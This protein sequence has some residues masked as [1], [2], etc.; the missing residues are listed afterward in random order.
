MKLA[1]ILILAL[2]LMAMAATASL[3]NTNFI[4]SAAPTIMTLNGR[5]VLASSIVLSA[6]GPLPYGTIPENESLFL[7]F[8]VPISFLEDINIIIK[9]EELVAGT[10]VNY[11]QLYDVGSPAVASVQVISTGG[12]R[13]LQ[14]AFPAE[15]TFDIN[16]TIEIEGVRLDVQSLAGAGEGTLVKMDITNSLGQAV[17]TNALGIEVGILREPLIMGP[18]YG[19]VSFFSDT[20]VISNV[21]TVTVDELFPNAFETRNGPNDDET[22][23][24][25]Q[26][27]NIPQGVRISGCQVAPAQSSV[28]VDFHIYSCSVGGNVVRV[29]IDDQNPTLWE[30]IAVGI[31]FEL[32]DTPSFQP[33]PADVDATLYPPPY[34][35]MPWINE[36]LFDIRFTG[37]P[38]AVSFGVVD[39]TT[40]LLAVYNAAY[41]DQV[42]PEF[43]S[44]NTGIGI[45]NQSGSSR[46][47]IGQYG[48]I[49]V[50]MYPQDGS[51]P[52]WF[53]TGPGM[54]PGMGLDVNGELPPKATWSVL[55]SELLMYAENGVG[56]LIPEGEFQGFIYFF[57]DFQKAEG[58][59]YIAD[60]S[61]QV[62]ADGY[63]MI[64]M[65]RWDM[66]DYLL[67]D[68]MFLMP[69]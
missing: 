45:I 22:D 20:G 56:A 5:T 27:S 65:N 29:E 55:V 35:N 21:A 9:D 6:T 47:G 49:T 15:V 60:G 67:S 1:K 24:W 44:L 3:A 4:R 52:Y 40:E 17:V 54:A 8:Q 33:S 16:E 48:A 2:A 7:T 42:M 50:E 30:R 10:I 58:V 32:Y 28:T 14:I 25:F 68:G 26:L 46:Y 63:Q 38:A 43:Y 64:N 62:F 57:C 53:T 51:G 69:N 59:N 66:I 11:N 41:R 39:L 36:L 18:T 31:E 12:Y 19:S 37:S 23:I 34:Y 61:F 13:T